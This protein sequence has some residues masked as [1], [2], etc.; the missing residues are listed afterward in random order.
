ML[1]ISWLAED[2]VVSM[3]GLNPMKFVIIQFTEAP[4]TSSALGP[5]IL[6]S[7]LSSNTLSMFFP[8]CESESTVKIIYFQL[9]IFWIGR[10]KKKYSD[11]SV[12]K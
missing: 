4:V 10:R 11:P 12:R 6:Y 9:Y 8:Q 1:G 3:E 2:L 7:T 5:N